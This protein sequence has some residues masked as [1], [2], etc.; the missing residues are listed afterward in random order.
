VEVE[1]VLDTSIFIALESGR[2]ILRND[3]PERVGVSVVTVGELRAGI[4]TARTTEARDQRMTTLMT[5]RR[6][7]PIPIDEE[8]AFAW[9]RLHI[10]L[11][12]K[13]RRM[14]RPRFTSA[15]P[16]SRRT[17]TT[18]TCR[19]STSSESDDATACYVRRR[20]SL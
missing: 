10:E 1:A 8:I 11:R 9:A 3:I 15:S 13:K 19:G 20:E 12:E 14:P 7:S 4:H 17:P 6:A 18:T 16:W 2:E 5:A